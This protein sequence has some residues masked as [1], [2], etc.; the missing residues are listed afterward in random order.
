MY[1][2]CYLLHI[3]LSSDVTGRDG[4][5]AVVHGALGVPA[6]HAEHR[7]QE[8]REPGHLPQERPPPLHLPSRHSRKDKR[9]SRIG[10][11]QKRQD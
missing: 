5:E 9:C 11:L 6:D 10:S 1:I 7:H 8:D 4:W 3:S 2:C